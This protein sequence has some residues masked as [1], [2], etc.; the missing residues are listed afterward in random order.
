MKNRLELLTIID[1]LEYIPLSNVTE[2]LV[3]RAISKSMSELGKT[4]SRAVTHYICS[5]HGFSENELLT[6]FDL[7][8]KSISESLGSAATKIILTLVKKE[9]LRNTVI[10]DP[11]LTVQEILNPDLSIRDIIARLN[12]VEILK[13]INNIPKQTHSICLYKTPRF[14][15][16]VIST[17]FQGKGISHGLKL[18]ISTNKPCVT[19][20]ND[21]E[22]ITYKELSE[23]PSRMVDN[24]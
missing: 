15:D 16:R 24:F 17:F 6:N 11:S 3:H 18:Y 5:T 7:F 1:E 19:I 2:E 13:F 20:P 22:C 8:E 12:H 23:K 9:L 10:I 14:R 21:V 4:G